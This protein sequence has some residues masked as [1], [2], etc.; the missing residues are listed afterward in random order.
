MGDLMKV[1]AMGVQQ[2]IKQSLYKSEQARV[3][4]VE[5]TVYEAEKIMT[6]SQRQVPVDTGRLK[7]SKFMVHTITKD[8]VVSTFGY[9]A[10]YAVYVHEMPPDRMTHINGKWKFLEDPLKAAVDGFQSRVADYVAKAMKG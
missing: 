3:L 2:T 7:N 5:A 4:F 10:D 6:E 1:L 9:R 8:G